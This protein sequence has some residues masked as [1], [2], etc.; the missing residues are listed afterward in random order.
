MLQS[1]TDVV[2]QHW[3]LGGI[4]ASL[5]WFLAGKQSFS[6]GKLDAALTWQ[7]VGVFVILVLLGWTI[8]EKEWLGSICSIGVLYFELWSIRRILALKNRG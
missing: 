3:V 5:T 1:F 6:N 2:K 4:G 8:A 7:A